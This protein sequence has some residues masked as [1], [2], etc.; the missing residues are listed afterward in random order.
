[1]ILRSD[2]APS[3]DRVAEVI[4]ASRPGRPVVALLDFPGRYN[5][6]GLRSISL[7]RLGADLWDVYRD[8]MPTSA[9]AEKFSHT[10]IR[11]CNEIAAPLLAIVASCA[12]GHWAEQMADAQGERC[13]IR[14]KV[15]SVNPG[16][17]S[18]P[19]VASE[20]SRVVGQL[21]GHPPTAI[22]MW[23]EDLTDVAAGNAEY[24]LREYVTGLL[25]DLGGD[26]SDASS[27]EFIRYQLGWIYYLSGALS[28]VDGEN[29]LSSEVTVIQHA[30]AGG[31]I[32]DAVS[33]AL[34]RL[35][36]PESS[37]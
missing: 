17:P 35:A 26:R 1:M 25:E 18:E 6:Y 8:A 28:T 23:K 20:V 32:S 14:P 12:S 13:G 33:D 5:E 11:R 27:V 31:S 2:P 7:E 36:A 21:G 9:A 29:G 10:L 30:P 19:E 15:I 3:G 4:S 16:V 22:G 34:F 24:R 37:E